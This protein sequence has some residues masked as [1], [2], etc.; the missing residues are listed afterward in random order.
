MALGRDYDKACPIF[1]FSTKDAGVMFP[2][3][4]NT[5]NNA[6]AA[7]Y[8]NLDGADLSTAVA[9]IKVPFKCRVI[10]CQA[11]ACVDDQGAKAA[12]A[13]AEPIIAVKYTAAT[14]LTTVDSATS[15]AIITCDG[16]GAVGAVWT[17][18]AGT[19]A[20]TLEEGYW[21]AAYLTTAASS[22]TSGNQDGGARVVV[23]LAQANAPA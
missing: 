4:L 22:A 15:L 16:A 10:T 23:W 11:Y 9:A 21:I 3:C 8:I 5:G 7:N 12:A 19:T 18:G 17:P 1:N 14:T 13:S 6:L 20:T 2:F